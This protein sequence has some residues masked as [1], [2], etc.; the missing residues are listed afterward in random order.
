[1]WIDLHDRY[2]SHGCLNNNWE[3]S[4][5]NFFISR[6]HS[7]DTV[8]DIGANIGWFSLVAAKHIGNTGV[9]HSFEPRPET[10]RMLIRTLALNNLRSIVH[11]WE[12]AL[13]DEAGEIEINWG[14]GTDNPGGSFISEISSKNKVGIQSARCKAMRLDD[15]LPDIKPDVIK[16]DVEGAE[17]LVFSGAVNALKRGRPVVLSELFP[18]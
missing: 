15:L 4:E 9:V 10:A 13:S 8:L 2:V 17:P 12:Y 1:M 6:L 18:S 14:V 7:G 11:A 3:P 5:T 16:I